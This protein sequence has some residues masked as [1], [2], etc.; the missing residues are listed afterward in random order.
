MTEIRDR[1]LVL[2]VLVKLMILACLSFAAYVLVAGIFWQETGTE[3]L[4][5]DVGAIE[6][7]KAGYFQ[8]GS[9]RLLV[10][11]KPQETTGGSSYLVVWA[12]DPIYGC[13]LRLQKESTRLKAVCADVVYDLEG[14]L[15]RGGVHHE[16]LVSPPYRRL[17]AHRLAIRLQ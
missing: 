17:D 12:E 3:E 4:V 16:D 1:R 6:A 11:G 15:L 14:R 9:R 8:V 13:D 7:G 10:V 5:I 2:R